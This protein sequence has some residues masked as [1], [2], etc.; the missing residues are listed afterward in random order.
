MKIVGVTYATA[1]FE[2]YARLLAMSA[3]RFGAAEFVIRRPDD[4]PPSF[5]RAH[6]S[7]LDERRGAG[8]WLWKPWVIVDQ[9]ARADEGDIV[10]WVDAASHVVGPIERITAVMERHGLD[11]WLMGHGFR[12]SQYTKRDAFVLLG[13]DRPEVAASPQRFAGTIAFRC[14][15]AARALAAEYLAAAI[16]RRVISDDPNTCGLANYADFVD[17]RHDQS[18]LSLLT[19]RAGIPVLD[20]GLVL[21]GLRPPGTHVVNHTRRSAPPH[22]VLRHLLEHRLVRFDEARDHFG[23]R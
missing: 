4:L 5:L 18:I 6:R 7:I 21:D 22:H 15:S 9:L 23:D 1:D 8:F 2:R 12:E 13:M 16:D 11:V 20:G 3:K 10:L 14:T 19:K 17:H